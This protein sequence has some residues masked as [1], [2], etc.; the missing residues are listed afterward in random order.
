M[1]PTVSTNR[2]T[3][4][5][6][7]ARWGQNTLWRLD[8]YVNPEVVGKPLDVAKADVRDV[9]AGV[10]HR[11]VADVRLGGDPLQHPAPGVKLGRDGIGQRSFGRTL[12][13]R[14]R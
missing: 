11:V 1:L 9:G 14:L 2:S 6:A 12:R 5:S 7:L 10:E 13:L 4:V 3:H 8:D